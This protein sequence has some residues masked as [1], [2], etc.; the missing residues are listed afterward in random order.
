LS[1]DGVGTLSWARASG[2]RLN[3]LEHLR[4]LGQAVVSQVAALPPATVRLLGLRGGAAVAPAELLP[5]DSA[6]ARKA[7]AFCAEISPP[8]LF[9]HCARCYLWGKL[10]ALKRGISFDPEALYVA[11]M[12][13]DAAL[14]GHSAGART[15]CD[16]F[17]LD[18]AEAALTM[19]REAGWSEDRAVGVA[20]AISLHL[21]PRVSLEEHGAEAHLM[22]ASAA[23]DVVGRRLGEIDPANVE[24][25]LAKHPRLGF[26]KAMV[27]L[28]RAQAKRA[29]RSRT[30]FLCRWLPFLALTAL[31]PFPE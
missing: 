26:K 13:H 18:G 8:T 1:R 15:G 21:N 7:E 29:P 14:T 10:L 30:G 3:R 2:G 16:C 23:L 4:L 24:A 19:L 31:A 5:P 12:L 9:N 27:Q 25:V 22:A 20:N 6:L 11:S 17:A 28:M